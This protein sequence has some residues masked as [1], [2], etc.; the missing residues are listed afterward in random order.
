MVNPRDTVGKA[1]EEADKINS[2][3][4]AE[5]R[6]AIKRPAPPSKPRMDMNDMWG[7]AAKQPRKDSGFK[8]Q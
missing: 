6:R 4:L 2:F 7:E 3:R 5:E 8:S 1:E